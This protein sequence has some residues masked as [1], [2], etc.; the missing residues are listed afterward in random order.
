ME[1]TKKDESIT[2]FPA[3]E[4]LLRA[5][6]CFDFEEKSDLYFVDFGIMPLFVQE[7]YLTPLPLMAMERGALNEMRH[8]ELCSMVWMMVMVV[9]K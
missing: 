6:G 9:M 4:K 7:N 3:A 5:E 1:S 8:L 2:T